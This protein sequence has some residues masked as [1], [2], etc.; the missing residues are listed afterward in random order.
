MF[1]KHLGFATSPHIIVDK[2]VVTLNYSQ[3]YFRYR[4]GISG[5]R[6]DGVVPYFNIIPEPPSENANPNYAIAIKE[7]TTAI[8]RVINNNWNLSSK[9]GYLTPVTMIEPVEILGS[10]I[11]SVTGHN[12]RI[13]VDG[14]IGPGAMIIVGLGGDAIPECYGVIKPAPVYAP[15]ISCEW[16]SSDVELRVLNPERYPQVHCCRIKYFL[17]C[18]DVKKWGL[19]TIWKLYNAGFRNVGKIIRTTV[20]QLIE[21]GACQYDGAT[22]LYE[23]LQKGISKVTVPKIM[24]GS[25]IFGE[26]LGEGIA[27]KFITNF[28]DWRIMTPSYQE[29]LSKKDFGP[30]RAT[31]FSTK[32][33]IFKDWLTQH[34]ELEGFTIQKVLKN[35]VLQGQV[36]T[37]TGF[38]D[39][40]SKGHIES[41][42]GKVLDDWRS[43]VTVV[44]ASNVNSNSKKTNKARESGGKTHLMSRNDFNNWL[45]QIRI[46]SGC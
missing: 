41:F 43:D 11:S 30:A 46:N 29:I 9:D 32:L 24:A 25:C 34:P 6:M 5:Y 37:F 27:D 16:N 15:D 38:T 40:I 12:A 18:L 31:M 35:N 22:G 17:D 8:T 14:G 36:F 39:D 13:I 28:P 3:Q 7:D 33:D 23:E 1:F 44:V 45:S 19:L 42:G 21:S 26:G 10:T 4:R 20:Q 2:S